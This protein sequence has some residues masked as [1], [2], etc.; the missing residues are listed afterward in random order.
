M[1][2]VRVFQDSAVMFLRQLRREPDS[3]LVFCTTPITVLTLLLIARASGRSDLLGIAVV[4]PGLMALFQA[5][6]FDAAEQLSADRARGVLEIMTAAPVS[7]VPVVLGR[8]AMIACFA[9]LALVESVLVVAAT[10]A[11]SVFRH[12]VE[13]VVVALMTVVATVATVLP[14]SVLFVLTRS[15]RLFQNALPWPVFLI[16]G[17]VVPLAMLPDW[18]HPLSQVVYLTWSAELLRAST[19]PGPVPGF[20]AGIAA[21]LT[22]AAVAFVLGLCLYRWAFARLRRDGGLAFA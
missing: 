15:V 10:G 11:G 6:L 8:A 20:F 4:A 14:L 21:I 9:L 17:V 12:P 19:H 22:S 2:A 5:A 1:R 16:S 7:L 18:T 3:W 13:V